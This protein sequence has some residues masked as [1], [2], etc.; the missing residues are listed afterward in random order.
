[1]YVCNEKLCTQCVGT[2]CRIAC[3]RLF[4]Q[5]PTTFSDTYQTATAPL[6]CSNVFFLPSE[7]LSPPPPRKEN[8]VVQNAKKT[9]KFVFNTKSSTYLALCK[10]NGAVQISRVTSEM[11]ERMRK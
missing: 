5:K 8:V 7:K 6:D 1:M 2:C 10:L 9:N 11:H 4:I 3:S